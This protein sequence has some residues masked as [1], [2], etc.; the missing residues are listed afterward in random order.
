MK[1]L[2][3]E[4]FPI[5]EVSQ[6]SGEEKGV[7]QGHISTLHMWWAR[8]PLAACRAIV[9][10]SLVDDPGPGPEREELVQLIRDLAR[11]DASD[12]QT[13]LNRAREHIRASTG[14]TAPS[15]L[16]I[17]AGGG[18]IPLEALR[19]GCDA[20]ALE[21]NP[22]AYLIL[23]CGLLYPQRFATAASAQLDLEGRPT[24]GSSRRGSSE[25]AEEVNRWVAW[26]RDRAHEEIGDL[27]PHDPDGSTPVAYLW[28]RTVACPNRTCGAEVPLLR[29]FWLVRKP[30]ARIA[31]RM[32]VDKRAKRVSFDIARGA[33]IDFDPDEGPRRGS[34]FQCPFCPA[35]GDEGYLEREGRANRIGQML[36]CVV[37]RALRQRGKRYRPATEAD[38][39]GFEKAGA[40]LDDIG[41]IDGLPWLPDE[42]LPPR[43]TLGFRIQKYGFTTWGSVYSARQAVA[44]VA[45]AKW[46]RAAYDEML[47]SGLEPDLAR[48][49]A[50]Y[51]AFAVDKVAVRGMS[52]CFWNTARETIENYINNNRVQMVWDF[53]ESNPFGGASGAWETGVK[54]IVQAIDHCARIPVIGSVHRGTA[55]RLPAEIP[56]VDAV[57]TDPPYYNS[58]PYSDYADLFYVWLRRTVGH[59]YPGHFDTRLSPEGPEIVENPIDRVGDRPKDRVFFEEEM[60]KALDQARRRV[61]DD[62]IVVVVFAHKT[63]FAWESLIAGLLGAGLTV[64]ASWPVVNVSPRRPRSLDSA[65]LGSSILLICRPRHAEAGVGTWRQ[66]RREL[67]AR[68][69]ER[70]DYFLSPD[71]GIRGADALLSTFGP[72]LESF[73]R[74]ERVEKVTGESVSVGEFL[75]E[76]RSAVAEHALHT[77]LGG[78]DLGDIDEVT[79]F[80]VL[81]RWTYDARDGKQVAAVPS[82]EARK[83]AQSVGAEIGSVSGRGGVAAI[84]GDKAKLLGPR[85]RR[86]VRELGET[87]PDGGPPPLVDVLHRA[88]NLWVEGGTGELGDFL[89]GKPVDEVQSVAQALSNLLPVDSAE[90][91]LYDGFLRSEPTADQPRLV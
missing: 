46:A 91:R 68:V 31:L 11:W 21:L 88:A 61:K 12:D 84:S 45:F 73:G 8:Q 37:T 1:R 59:L 53:A 52:T 60:T 87:A 38:L 67:T 74:Y 32:R 63:T 36:T 22:V 13:L 43:G 54:Y 6:Q 26:V 55:T 56:M 78:R 2:I 81:W 62:G 4:F 39:A 83:L 65:A 16:D 14:G 86:S 5:R 79:A 25:L 42:S 20:H 24:S 33:D 69:R 28:A 17:F 57:I 3:E 49:V 34:T 44:V 18:A 27:Y 48:A 29:H 35:A 9:L 70:L 64:T 85:D 90:K 30:N 77:V 10:A 47:R 40:F 41:E 19:L 82:D 23:S 80:Y 75:D 7:R 51:V 58:V 72:A 76:V 71:V 50:T 89:R 66:V 15:V